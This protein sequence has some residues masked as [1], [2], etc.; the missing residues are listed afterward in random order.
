M[1]NLKPFTYEEDEKY[2]GN[3]EWF[4]LNKLPEG[5]KVRI[6]ILETLVSG[7]EEWTLENKPIRY[8]AKEKPK[9]LK[10]PTGKLNEFRATVIWNY[11]LER[12]QTWSFHQTGVRSALNALS[13]S[14]GN[15]L[16]YDIYITR[17]GQ[18]KETR[19]L[20]KDCAPS[21]IDARIQNELDATPLNLD[22]LFSGGDPW[23][24]LRSDEVMGGSH[25]VA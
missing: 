18:N 7:W 15:P 16:G 2:M 17:V 20:L 3:T 22:V 8:R 4:K 14:K 12:L 10:N 6:R 19:Y 21:I 24:I 23:K 5:E 25:D 9:M 1:N 11:D 13:Q